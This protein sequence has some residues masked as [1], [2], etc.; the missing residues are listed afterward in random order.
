MNN[1]PTPQD[2]LNERIQEIETAHHKNCDCPQCK[3]KQQM[4]IEASF[5]EPT[6]NEIADMVHKNAIEKG[7]HDPAESH[8]S[9]L[10]NQCNNIHGEIT[11]LWD[12]WRAGKEYDACDKPIH[13]NCT[14]EELADLIIRALDVSRRLKI[15]I[16][17]AI[18][19]K[20]GYNLTRP[21]KH[22]KL[23]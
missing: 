22:G 1:P 5:S 14:E 19:V 6:L 2:I 18:L 20:H 7:F 13:L 4:K 23:N 8:R 15:D 9:F 10:A 21:H 3:P 17:N 16:L 12:A 11:E